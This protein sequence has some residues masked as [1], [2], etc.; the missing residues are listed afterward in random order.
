MSYRG[1]YKGSY[2]VLVLDEDRYARE[3]LKQLLVGAGFDAETVA[4]VEGF[5]K[6][7]TWWK[8][9]SVVVP[10]ALRGESGLG[11]VR[12]VKGEHPKLPVVLTAASPGRSLALLGADCGA[13]EHLSTLE[14]Y[15]GVVDALYAVYERYATATH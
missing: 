15:T 14:G 2:K 8:P 9:T 4:D 12:R 11:L 7:L 5:E 6:A 10:A 1:S 13:D 3:V